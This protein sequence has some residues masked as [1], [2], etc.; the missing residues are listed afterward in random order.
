MDE[1]SLQDARTVVYR[2]LALG[3]MLKRGEYEITVQ[4]LGDFM[5]SEDVRTHI[6]D[7]HYAHNTHLKRWA[8]QENIFP[9]LT[10]EENRLLDMPLAQ[11]SER[12]IINTSWRVES[13]GILLWALNIIEDIPHYDTQFEP[14][15][16][17]QPLEILKPTIDLVWRAELRDSE[18]IWAVR[19]LAEIWHWRSRTTEVQR[20]GVQAPAGISF[21][22]IIQMAAEK[23]HAD[24]GIPRPINGDFPVF[25]KAYAEINED[26]YSLTTSIAYERH[27]V[28]NW[29]CRFSDDWD[30]TPTDT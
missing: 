1:N 10:A 27:F 21:A 24:G 7:K 2:A 14:D 22:Q 17:M 29:L 9:Y 15:T 16:V 20:M 5:L 18:E 23:A 13:L 12:D 30:N 6:I 8:Q 26:Q 11:W 25:G 28:M 4:N 3:T 19:D